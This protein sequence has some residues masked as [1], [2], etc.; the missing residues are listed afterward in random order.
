MFPRLEEGI[1]IFCAWIPEFGIK[2][3]DI[4]VVV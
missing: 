4:M 1:Y 3:G 2:P